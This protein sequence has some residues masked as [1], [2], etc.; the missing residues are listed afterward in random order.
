MK[1]IPLSKL[2]PFLSLAFFG[3]ALWLLHGELKGFRYRDVFN[4]FGQLPAS[5]VLLAVAF[6]IAGYFALTGYDTLAIRYIGKEV[7][8][9]KIALASFAGYAFSNTLGMPLFT[10]TPLRARLY[11][12]WGLTA[13]DIARIVLLS[14]ATFWLGFLGLA[15][16]AFLLEP[17]AV[18]ARLHL[19]VAS[20]RPVGALFLGIV[21]AYLI[22][23]VVRRRP[24][25]LKGMELAIPRPGMGLMQIA[26]ASLDWSLAGAVLYAL[27]PE[28]W[29]ITPFHFLG[30][31]LFAQVAGLLSHVPGGLG[32][33]ES[34]MV[35]LL[36]EL[37][38]PQLLAAMV[39]YRA[40]YYFMPLLVAAVSLG[41]HEIVRRRHQVGRLA[42]MFGGRAPDVVPQIL[43][44]TTFLG[45]AILLVSGATPAV[46]S[47][48]SWLKDALPLSVIEVSHFLGS[49][50]GVLLLFLAIGLQR[51]IDAAYQLTV[52]LLASG[53]VFSL[54]KGLDYE[55]SI[56]LAIMLAALFPCHRHFFRKASLT[57]EP[58]TPGWSLAI[59]IVLL[60]SVW[61]GFFAYK[62]VDYSRDLWWHFTLFGNAPRFLRASV[63]VAAV[64]LGV[65]VSRLLRAAPHEPSTPT[66]EEMTKAATVAAAY[67]RTYAWLA[68]IGDKQLLFHDSGNAYVM[69]GVEHKTW[70]SMGDPVGPDRER[71]ELVWKFR[72]LVDRHDGWTCFYQ[73]ND[74][75]LH[76]Y[77]DL[78]LTLIKLGEEARVPLTS[79]SLAGSSRKKLRWAQRKCTEEGCRFEVLSIEQAA[80]LL[81]ELERISDEWLEHKNTREKAFSLGYFNPHYLRR[82]PIALIYKEERIVAFA[83][84]WQGGEKEEVSIDLMRHTAD[85]PT[86][87][88]DYLFVELMLYGQAQGFRWFNLGMAPLAGLEARTIAPLW[89]RL[90]ALVFRHGEHFYNFQGL[91]Q[92]K[93]KFEPVWESRYLA[94]PG[95]LALPRVLSDIATLISRGF[96]G[97]VAK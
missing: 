90:G 41:V 36:P 38:H 42:R 94:C 97:V 72:E 96:R 78:G 53:V 55:E 29:N 91:R 79:F 11:S 95:G 61:L 76:L 73:V 69:F 65:A 86:G 3:L 89:S 37:P 45:G 84:L 87:V 88:M 51:R 26:V 34:M 16:V 7:A 33:F 82:F 48:L 71:A 49:L 81:P 59:A 28:D 77:A 4:F 75:S 31:F 54:A 50:A 23:T 63:G 27:L 19:P 56:V 35:L 10:G 80:P 40:V 32:V 43:A 22:L 6:T 74:K 20:A 18:P 60:G 25:V 5:R 8:Y 21:L 14:Y 52:I 70:V 62:H 64:A 93:D 1:K 15:G 17:I 30:V 92:Y 85:A 66:E 83:N 44:V 46:H 68:L 9:W 58:F 67:P 39:A 2:T 24:V 47:R 13:L 12:G 57:A